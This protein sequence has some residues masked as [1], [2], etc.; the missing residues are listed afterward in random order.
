M[1]NNEGTSFQV[2]IINVAQ[3]LVYF[4]MCILYNVWCQTTFVGGREP[5][6]EYID[7]NEFLM[8][9]SNSKWSLY[10]VQILE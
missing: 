2:G 4:I 3:L 8:K 6:P 5:K 9:L 10:F 7:P 1:Y